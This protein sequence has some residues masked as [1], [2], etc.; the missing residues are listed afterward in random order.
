MNARG[1]VIGFLVITAA[2][3]GALVWA[4]SRNHVFS[5][6]PR[7][8]AALPFLAGLS[9]LAYL[10]RYA[11]LVLAAGSGRPPHARRT[12]ISRVPGRLR[13]HGDAR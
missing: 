8:L 10:V 9:M 3:L 4:D 6:L 7:L 5:A 12:R 1:A 13:V 2:Y 11:A